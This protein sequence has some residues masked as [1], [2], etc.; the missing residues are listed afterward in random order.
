MT[1]NTLDLPVR[2]KNGD[3]ANKAKQ[4]IIFG[5]PLLDQF[6]L[7]PAYHNL[8]QGSFGTIPRPVQAK[9][10]EYQDRAEARPDP[11][12]RYEYPKL[13]DES[14]EAVAKLLRAP[15]DTVVFVS[16]ATVAVNTV[17][18]NL[19]WNVDGKDEILYFSTTYGGCAKTIDCVVDSSRGLVKSREI[20]LAYPV[21]DDEVLS[22]FRAAVQASK[23][24]GKRSVIALY[25]VISS[26][27]GV[28]FPFEAMT[29]ACRELGV[30]SLV[31]GAQ[32]IGLIDL[33]L[34]KLDPDFFLTNCHKWLHV[35]RGCAAFY[36]PVRNQDLIRTS[37]ATSHGY[38]SRG[39]A[40][41]LNPLPPSSKSRFVNE[42]EF[43]GTIDNSPYL[44]CKDAIKWRESIG[45][46]AKII[47][48]QT[49][50]AKEGGK[51][52]AEIL[53]TQVLDNKTGTLTNCGMVNVAL[54]LVIVDDD[55]T[56]E[57]GTT[58]E[59]Y[60]KVPR[61]SAFAFTQ[62]L[63]QTLMSEYHT[64]I[65]LGVI[66]NRWWARL[67]AQVYLD[68]DDFEWT[69]KTLKELCERAA[70]LDMVTGKGA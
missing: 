18:K 33:D 37:L 21:E 31:D 68:M 56:S 65:A 69:G 66:Q 28:R 20:G 42:F 58:E 44:A 53:G 61:K 64:F 30:M 32:G 70:S 4:E 35:P 23:D 1:L 40:V 48:Y 46:E 50:L 29:E 25:D 54:P 36:V 67:S 7:D 38:V 55:D 39:G 2:E 14:R 63:L 10:R 43:V 15:T 6:L 51:K 16:N 52:V 27:P 47:E 34:G 26:I 3:V 13:L 57:G 24:E 62:W 60:L 45:G 41:R 22:K 5:R 9:L 49:T 12:I 17:L 19:V 11:F 59:G 8:N